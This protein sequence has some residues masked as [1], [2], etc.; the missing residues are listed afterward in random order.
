MKVVYGEG[1]MYYVYLVSLSMINV[2][3]ILKLPPE[4]L[5]LLSS[6][7]RSIHAILACRVVLHTRQQAKIQ[8][9]VLGQGSNGET[10]TSGP[11]E[12]LRF[13]RSDD[14]EEIEAA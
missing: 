5:A 8:T 13:V 2:V 14:V 3:V 10:S 12:T 11:T 9:V 7:M 6:P 1:I 4:Y